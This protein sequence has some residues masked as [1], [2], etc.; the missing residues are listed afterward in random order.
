MDI[1]KLW[2]TYGTEQLGVACALGSEH[3]VYGSDYLSCLLKAP[4]PVDFQKVLAIEN[5]PSQVD[6][7]RDLQFYEAFVERT[8]HDDGQ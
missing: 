1:Y 5:A 3:E 7:D 6:V 2:R 4:K 8:G